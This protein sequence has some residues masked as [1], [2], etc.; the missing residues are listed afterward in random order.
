MEKLLLKSIRL[1]RCKSQKSCNLGACPPPKTHS[2]LNERRNTHANARAHTHISWTRL[3]VAINF[4]LTTA[5]ALEVET[6]DYARDKSDMTPRDLPCRP[7]ERGFNPVLVRW[8]AFWGAY[9]ALSVATGSLNPVFRWSC[10][11][12]PSPFSLS[13]SSPSFSVTSFSMPLLRHQRRNAGKNPKQIQ[14]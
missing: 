14:C 7:G 11:L 6:I 5:F 4:N 8:K 3:R 2:G 13:L 12:R 1:T 10:C 9:K